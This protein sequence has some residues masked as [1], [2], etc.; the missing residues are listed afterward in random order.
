MQNANLKQE[1]IDLS[2]EKWRWMSERKIDSRDSLF[3]EK[4]VFVHRGGS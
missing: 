4:A 3:Q 2:T 1:V